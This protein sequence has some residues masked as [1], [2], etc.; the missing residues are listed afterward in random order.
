MTPTLKRLME[1][2]DKAMPDAFSRYKALAAERA[3]WAAEVKGLRR[4]LKIAEMDL[5]IAA[6]Y[7]DEPD[8]SA[9]LRSHARSCAKTLVSVRAALK[10]ETP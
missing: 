9:G 7:A 4:A 10:G 8:I 2:T 1:A 3:A 5:A 6:S